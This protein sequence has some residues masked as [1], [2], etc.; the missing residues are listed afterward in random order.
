MLASHWPAPDEF[1]ATERLINGLFNDG[2]GQSIAEALR[3]SQLDLMN[4]PVTSH[5]FYWAGFALIGDGSRTFLPS[6][7]S[8]ATSD[9]PSARITQP[10]LK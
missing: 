6:S 2:R 3:Q 10:A 9:A 8:L 7:T 5:P 4:D 1:R